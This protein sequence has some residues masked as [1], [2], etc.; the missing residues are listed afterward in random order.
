[1]IAGATLAPFDVVL[2]RLCV[3]EREREGGDR[4]IF[5]SRSRPQGHQRSVRVRRDANASW[6]PQRSRCLDAGGLTQQWQK[7]LRP[8]ARA[9]TR[10]SPVAMLQLGCASIANYSA[11]YRKP[12][13]TTRP[14]VSDDNE[15]NHRITQAGLR[16]RFA[17][18][19]GVLPRETCSVR[20]FAHNMFA[21]AHTL[22][23]ACANIVACYARSFRFYRPGRL[24]A[25]TARP[26]PVRRS[27]LAP[28]AAAYAALG[29]CAVLE[30]A[31]TTRSPSALWVLALFPL[32]HVAYAAGVLSALLSSRVIR[33]SNAA[34]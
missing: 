32:Q 15:I 33:R 25:H 28:A 10:F 13:P 17:A 5:R 21:Y 12:V 20:Q 34:Q 26:V 31:W 2:H 8:A 1:M 7:R 29:A 11:L 16:F 14:V 19:A 9:S 4:N 30:V 18:N 24:L 6:L 3:L 22:R 23:A 27:A